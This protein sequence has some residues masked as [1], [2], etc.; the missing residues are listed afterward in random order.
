MWLVVCVTIERFIVTL[1]PLKARVICTRRAAIG[2]VTFLSLGLLTLWVSIIF[3]DGVEGGQC[4]VQ[5]PQFQ[6]LGFSGREK[7]LLAATVYT[8]VPTPLLFIFNMC[9]IFNLVKAH[10]QRSHMLSAQSIDS[11]YRKQ[12]RT[13]M[14]VVLVSVCYLLL[15][16]PRALVKGVIEPITSPDS[17]SWPIL[18]LFHGITTVMII[19]NH[20]INLFLYIFTSARMRAEFKRM[21]NCNA[22]NDVRT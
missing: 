20:S 2:V 12:T 14:M 5:P 4:V 10:R 19:T 16:F 15:T 18:E 3:K 22:G 13:T 11:D 8:F 17:P 21:L 7:A 1:L 9:T 6:Y